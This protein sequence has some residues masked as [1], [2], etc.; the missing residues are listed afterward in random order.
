PPAQPVILPVVVGRS[1]HGRC[2]GAVA[3]LGQFWDPVRRPRRPYL[4]PVWKRYLLR[5][6]LTL[7]LPAPR[8]HEEAGFSARYLFCR[9]FCC[10]QQTLTIF[11][12]NSSSGPS[13]L[14]GPA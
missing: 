5:L 11:I 8:L 1:V 13:R 6:R 9:Q 2:L 12:A 4:D 14:R 7:P 3:E 10:R